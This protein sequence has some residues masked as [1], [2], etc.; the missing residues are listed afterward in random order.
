MPFLFVLLLSQLALASQIYTESDFEADNDPLLMEYEIA[1][2]FFCNEHVQKKNNKNKLEVN[3]HISDVDQ[4]I[5]FNTD[6]CEKAELISESVVNIASVNQETRDQ[7]ADVNLNES[8]SGQS[9]KNYPRV[10]DQFRLDKPTPGLKVRVKLPPSNDT[11]KRK[12]DEVEYATSGYSKRALKPSKSPI[13]DAFV[14]ILLSENSYGKIN[15]DLTISIDD[16]LGLID[17]TYKRAPKKSKTTDL[18][19][20]IK[21]LKRIFDGIPSPSEC[22]IKKLTL[23]VKEKQKQ[24]YLRSLSRM[25]ARK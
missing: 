12:R 16:F 7:D 1:P 4:Y 20:Q 18:V 25:K 15:K 3:D 5:N 13:L 11:N 8:P 24:T 2:S 10:D 9:E 22:S 6:S 14:Y 23:R 17:E 19:S 21:T